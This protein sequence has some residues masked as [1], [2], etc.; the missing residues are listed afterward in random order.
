MRTSQILEK[1]DL[2]EIDMALLATPLD[3]PGVLEIPVYYE[4]FIAYVSPK[5]PLYINEVVSADEVDSDR[6]WIL[7]EGHCLRNQVFNFCHAKKN[8]SSYE[9]GSID[10]LVKVVDANGGFTI[11]PELHIDFLSQEQKQN[12]RQLKEP[13]PVR[14][15][16][17]VVREDFVK[18]KFLNIVADMIKKLVPDTM[19]DPRLKK[20]KIKL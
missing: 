5:D 19:L 18:E 4:K 8:V 2:A 6:L 12:L 16:S 15:I 3:K 14:E 9:A 20:F 10:T 11:I 7:A 13:V 17:L 1:L